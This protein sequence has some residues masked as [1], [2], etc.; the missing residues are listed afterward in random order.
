MFLRLSTLGDLLLLLG[1][2]L[3]LLN[4]SVLIGR[5]YRTVLRVA[6]TDA[7]TPEPAEVNP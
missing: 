7:T 1:N 3:F 4:V 5:Y 2:L 6:Y